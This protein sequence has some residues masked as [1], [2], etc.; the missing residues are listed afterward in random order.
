MMMK[1]QIMIIKKMQMMAK[2]K[3]YNT[4]RLELMKMQTIRQTPLSLKIN[5]KLRSLSSKKTV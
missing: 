5:L 4:L 2:I 1:K 3:N